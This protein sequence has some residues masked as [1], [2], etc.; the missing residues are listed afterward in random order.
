VSKILKKNRTTIRKRLNLKNSWISNIS[1]L[2]TKIQIFPEFFDKISNLYNKTLQN[3]LE[4][5]EK[6]R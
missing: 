2:K 1:I 4:F 6:Y 3:S 5:F